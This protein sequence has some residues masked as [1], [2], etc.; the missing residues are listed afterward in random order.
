MLSINHKTYSHRPPSPHLPLFVVALNVRIWLGS[1]DLGQ[2]LPLDGGGAGG[3]LAG[4]GEGASG[5]PGSG[6]GAGGSGGKGG[7]SGSG[8][9]VPADTGRLRVK[10][11]DPQVDFIIPEDFRSS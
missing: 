5:E 3:R 10:G 11:P 8:G 1:T 7:K 4:G 6:A 2:P 9:K